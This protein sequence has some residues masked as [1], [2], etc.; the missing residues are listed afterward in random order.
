MIGLRRNSLHSWITH[1]HPI[2]YQDPSAKPA[3]PSRVTC[4]PFTLPQ[5][6]VDVDVPRVRLCRARLAILSPLTRGSSRW[7]PG[8][9]WVHSSRSTTTDLERRWS[10]SSLLSIC[11]SISAWLLIETRR[12]S[13]RIT[14]ADWLRKVCPSWCKDERKVVAVATLL[15]QKNWGWGM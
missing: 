3:G 8:R 5:V 7:L 14:S 11:S 2:I 9:A 1:L 13:P 10:A 6:E 15:R 12:T 4:R